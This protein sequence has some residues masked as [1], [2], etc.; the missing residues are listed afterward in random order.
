VKKG[1][2]GRGTTMAKEEGPHSVP[3]NLLKERAQHTQDV[4]LLNVREVLQVIK[5]L[6]DRGIEPM[7][8]DV[9]GAG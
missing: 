3:P 1:R 7:A 4:C 5:D 2:K 9:A 8:A 6:C